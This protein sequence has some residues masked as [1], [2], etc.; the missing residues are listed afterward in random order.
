MGSSVTT[1]R[2]GHVFPGWD[3]GAKDEVG[4]RQHDVKIAEVPLV[5]HVMMG[6]QPA[7]A[8]G[9]FQPAAFWNM[10]T[11]VEV[12][13]KKVIEHQR[14]QGAAKYVRC[15][16]S[17]EPKNDRS[18]EQDNEWRVPPGKAHFPDHLCIREK[19]VVA[20]LEEAVVHA[21]RG[22]E[23]GTAKAACALNTYAES[24]RRSSHI[25]DNRRK[26]LSR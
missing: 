24:I 6:I 2:G 19:I 3:E 18:V 17:L 5:M 25:S 11:V 22:R 8:S 9:G 26:P 16:S 21:R 15:Q 23:R 10:H 20:G 4:Y 1:I 7:E 14:R 13:I 12:F